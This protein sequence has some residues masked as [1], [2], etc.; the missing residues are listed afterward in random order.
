MFD[1]T[2]A[3]EIMFSVGFSSFVNVCV[4]TMLCKDFDESSKD[5]ILRTK[6]KLI[7]FLGISTFNERGINYVIFDIISGICLKNIYLYVMANDTTF[8]NKTISKAVMTRSRL[9]N[10]FLKYQ[11]IVIT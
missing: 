11:T 8:M 1:L 3:K 6:E 10:E 7:K 4:R 2:A 9:K 5:Y